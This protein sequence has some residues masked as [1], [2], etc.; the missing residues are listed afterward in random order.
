MFKEIRPAI[1]L[2]IAF[3][4]ITGL[5]YPLVMTGIAEV[6]FP[7]QAQWQ[8]DREGRQGGRLRIDRAIFH[9]RSLFPWPP[10]GHAWSRSQRPEQDVSVPYN[11]AN[12]MGSN[13]GP[14]SKA[15]IDRVKG[16]VDKLKAENPSAQVPVDL[17]TTSGSGLDP[18]ISPE[19]RLFPGAPRREGPQHA[20]RSLRRSSPSTSR[21]GPWAS[22]ASRA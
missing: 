1:V 8:P 14:T 15:L 19:A 12:S 20:G 11:A 17:V 16:D 7:H 4:I 5:V 3:T 13:L 21:A 18:H 22:S 6:I 2:I 9:Q 10:V